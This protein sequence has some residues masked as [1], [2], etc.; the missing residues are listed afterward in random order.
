MGGPKHLLEIAG[1]P[2]LAR[3][4]RALAASHA[5]S[6]TC[7]LRAGDAR[8]AALARA[9]GARCARV[10]ASGEGRA[11]SIRAALEAAPGDSTAFLIAQGDQPFLT[12][13]DFDALIA[14]H[15]AEPGAIVH[16][17]YGGR[18][19][20]PVLF[21]AR[22]RGALLGLRGEEGG[23]VLLDREPGRL[24]AVA[25]DPAHGRDVDTPGDLAETR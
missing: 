4:L 22:D 14:A 2:M 20:S 6:V 11:A 7:A 9:E 1:A 10:P 8:G 25:L 17:S 24:R 23:R 18:R 16:A 12:G 21:P 5:A 3:V 13:A 19:G 15:E